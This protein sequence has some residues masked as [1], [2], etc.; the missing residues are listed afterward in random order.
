[1]LYH[2]SIE[3]MLLVDKMLKTILFIY[4]KK[5]YNLIHKFY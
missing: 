5:S 1:M 4:E 3:A 2:E